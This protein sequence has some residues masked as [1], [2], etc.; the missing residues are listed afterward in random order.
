[1][2]IVAVQAENHLE[3]VYLRVCMQEL[4]NFIVDYR[5]PHLGR[6][7]DLKVEQKHYKASVCVVSIIHIIWFISKL[8]CDM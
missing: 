6:K 8:I 3:Y 2:Y 5:H 4:M 1:M 7:Q